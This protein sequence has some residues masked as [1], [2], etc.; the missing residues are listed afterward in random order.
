MWGNSCT[1][2]NGLGMDC[3]YL[4]M[5]LMSGRSGA[6]LYTAVLSAASLQINLEHLHMG[7]RVGNE[8][9]IKNA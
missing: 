7:G 5:K 1:I 6:G 3:P 8:E 9:E 2:Q 4:N